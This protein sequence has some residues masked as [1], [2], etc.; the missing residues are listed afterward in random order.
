MAD[1]SAPASQ[2]WF[3]RNPKKTIVIGLFIFLLAAAYG[4]E[5]FLAHVNR[6]HSLVLF[7]DRRYINLREVPPRID[8][9]AVPTDKEVRT[10][11]GLVQKPYRVRTDANGLMLPYNHYEKPDLTLVFLGGS[12]T[13]CLYVDEDQRYPSLV[14][15]VLEQK[16]GKKITSIN[17]GVGGNNSLH[18]IDILLNKI[19]PIR[20]DVVVMMQNI[21][22]LATLIYD[23]NYWG[24]NPTGRPII[25]FY[26]Y[27]NLKG[28]KGL[29]TLARDMYIPNLHA[30]TRVLSHKIFGKKVKEHDDEFAYI[31]GKKLIIDAAA[32]TDEFKMNLQ[33][34]IN[35]CRARRITPVLMTQFNRYKPS[36]D[37]KVLATMKGFESNSGISVSEFIDLYAKFNEAIRE[38]GKEN[39]V[40]VIDLANLIPQDSK[41]IYDE[42]HLNTKGS[43]LAAQVISD[44]LKP[45]VPQ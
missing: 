3:E 24:Q 36:P 25:D 14:G 22:D 10:S 37:P 2:N 15:Q 34:F 31:R 45:M 44:Q 11:D 42:V 7:T 32:I 39:G 19:I 17:S 20:P 40:Q 41:Y 1:Q 28:L 35:I 5:K 16:T 43:Q 23:K 29:S 6:T 30:A 26:F 13:F 33:T 9:M 27:K 21:N 4:T 12:T 38:V 8:T 18:S